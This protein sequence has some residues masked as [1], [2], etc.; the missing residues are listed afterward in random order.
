MPSSARP[1][2]RLFTLVWAGESIYLLPYALRRDYG[3]T[4]LAWLEL[5]GEAELGALYSFFGALS[6]VAYLGGGWL[7]DRVAPRSL[8]AV[9]LALT[10]LGG[11]ILAAGPSLAGAYGLFTLWALSTIF[12]FWA[13]L[14]KATRLEGGAGAQGRAFGVLDGGRGLLAALAATAGLGLFAAFGPGER[15]L[16]AV[17]ALYAGACVVGMGLSLALLPRS[18]DASTSDA[19][20][21]GGA[22]AM[23][24]EAGVGTPWQR[25]LRVLERPRTWLLGGVVFAAYA[26]FWGTFYVAG[27]ATAAHG[28]GPA[29]AAA[30]SVFGVWV[31]PL[32]ALGA[33][34]LADRLGARRVVVG[35]FVLLTLAC[36]SLALVPPAAGGLS[37]LYVQAGLLALGAYALRGV[38]FAMLAEGGLPTVLTG[39]AVGVISF[40]GFAPDLLLPYGFGRLL[41]GLPGATGYRAL[42]ATLTLSSMAGGL[43]AALHAPQRTDPHRRPDSVPPPA[44]ATPEDPP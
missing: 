36:G 25:T 19:A 5:E 3:P 34:L 15:G 40:M 29:A 32:A 7:A 24:P 20:S 4:L 2:L 9:A 1:A 8:F 42:F 13:A 16:L 18:G 38:Y 37:G 11:G 35:C 27:F 28:Q 39:T 21:T 23:V 41:D 44:T 6:L 12:L 33:G 26:A 31:R 30:A 43:C 17:I 14:I 10:A 22:G